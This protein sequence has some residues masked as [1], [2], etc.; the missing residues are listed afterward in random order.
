MGTGISW[1]VYHGSRRYRSKLMTTLSLMEPLLCVLSI[2]CYKWKRPLENS[3]R[4][5]LQIKLRTCWRRLRTC[6]LYQKM[7]NSDRR[8]YR[9]IKTVWQALSA[10]THRK[11]LNNM[12]MLKPY[13]IPCNMSGADNVFQL[14]VC[15]NRGAVTVCAICR[16]PAIN[17]R[18]SYMSV[19]AV[20]E[21]IKSVNCWQTFASTSMYIEGVWRSAP[22][23]RCW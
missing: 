2:F 3:I 18:W 4:S 7:E 21:K 22:S 1:S 12:H 13:K 8:N 5:L 14:K 16:L 23:V 17:Y 15:K 9:N 11:S 6:V 10:V 19:E 20:L